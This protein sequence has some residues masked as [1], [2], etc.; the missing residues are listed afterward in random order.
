M[1]LVE[2]PDLPLGLSDW[3]SIEASY[4]ART[5]HEKEHTCPICME[6]L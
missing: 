2:R 4:L 6:D 3:K 5:E 1:G